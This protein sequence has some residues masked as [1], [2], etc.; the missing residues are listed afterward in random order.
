MQKFTLKEDWT[1]LKLDVELIVPDALDLEWMRAKGPQPGEQLMA[2]DG[3]GKKI[4]PQIQI[5]VGVVNLLMV[6]KSDINF[7]GE[8]RRGI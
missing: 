4:K 1:P 2:D 3:E 5:D 7:R 8:R 6:I